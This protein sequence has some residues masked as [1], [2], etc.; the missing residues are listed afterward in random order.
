MFCIER[1]SLRASEIM[2][3]GID[4]KKAISSNHIDNL[5]NRKQVTG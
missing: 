2:L 1:F 3:L 4:N 5:L